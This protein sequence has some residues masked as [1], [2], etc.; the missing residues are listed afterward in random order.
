[1][2]IMV[3][4]RQESEHA[5]ESEMSVRYYISSKKLTA[6]E[7]HNATKNHWLVESMHWQL[8][9][10]FNEDAC[11]IRVDDRADA[12]SR[13]RQVCLNLLKQ[14]TSFKGGLNVSECVVLW[15]KST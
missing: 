4:V 2:G 12:L 5:Q 8:D 6:E 7:L 1:M 3:N 14:E 10:G 11:R 15:M 13:I 9:V